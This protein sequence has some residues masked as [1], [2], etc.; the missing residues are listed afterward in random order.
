ME[1]LYL[2]IASILGL[3]LLI[4]V[5]WLFSTGKVSF[6]SFEIGKDKTKLELKKENKEETVA[7]QGPDTEVVP[8][9]NKIIIGSKMFLESS[10]LAEMMGIMIRQESSEL[11]VELKHKYGD[12]IN[13]FNALK[14]GN[15]H[16]YAEYSGTILAELLHMGF[17]EVRKKKFHNMSKINELLKINQPTENLRWLDS[18]GFS[19]PYVLVMRRDKAKEFGLEEGEGSCNISMLSKNA[20]GKL[21][22]KF[23]HGWNSQEQQKGTVGL[24][25]VY[26]LDFKLMDVISHEHKYPALKGGDID[27]TDG[28]KTD[29]E[30]NREGN[31]FIKL[32]DDRNFFP[33]YEAGPL[34]NEKLLGAYPEVINALKKLTGKIK[35]KEMS[36]LIY[37]VQEKNLTQEEIQGFEDKQGELQDIITEFLRDDIGVL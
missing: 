20:N 22:F 1:G 24:M 26:K 12:T 30:I 27:I 36:D 17:S 2:T 4:L 25:K 14:E 15:I 8:R 37:R 34:I 16:L 35:V 31:P 21:I 6:F 7:P 5:G 10:I 18:F 28:Y 13:N 19:N 11:K 9:D 23:T 33:E 32:D 3:V 29:P